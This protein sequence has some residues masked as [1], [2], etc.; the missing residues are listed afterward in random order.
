M[1][2]TATLLD[3]MHTEDASVG[4]NV[5]AS[6][7]VNTTSTEAAAVTTKALIMFA[8]NDVTEWL[9]VLAIIVSIW[10][11]LFV[12]CWKRKQMELLCKW[13]GLRSEKEVFAKLTESSGV[14]V[15]YKADE[16]FNVTKG[17]IEK[18]PDNFENLN[19][20]TVCGWSILIF[21]IVC[22]LAFFLTLENL[23]RSKELASYVLGSL[24]GVGMDVLLENVNS[25]F[26]AKSLVWPMDA[27]NAKQLSDNLKKAM[28]EGQS[29][30]WF[31]SLFDLENN[32]SL[33]LTVLGG[34][35][36]GIFVA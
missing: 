25:T 35:I 7:V 13:D 22:W 31:L 30:N 24:A 23:K 12:G 2:A 11:T 5:N 33:T 6:D 17:R 1:A 26:S 18:D 29:R 9:V 27:A 14:R 32:S 4:V 8:T 28:E 19:R 21:T 34:L 10:A 15:S 20:V 36:N 16:T 3:L